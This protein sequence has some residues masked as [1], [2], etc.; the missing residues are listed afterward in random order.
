MRA[1][2]E[3]E[4]VGEDDIPLICVELTLR[5]EVVSDGNGGI[6]NSIPIIPIP[7]VQLKACTGRGNLQ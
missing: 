1:Q 7:R 2:F 6:E 5:L 4:V 3:H